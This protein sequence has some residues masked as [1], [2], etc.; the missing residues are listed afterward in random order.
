MFSIR[1]LCTNEGL[2]K[3]G[4]TCAERDYQVTETSAYISAYS[5]TQVYS[6]FF[7][8]WT[9][10]LKR[11]AINEIMLIDKSVYFTVYSYKKNCTVWSQK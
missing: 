6:F 1:H 7:S 9:D 2:L 5:A 8:A 4:S 3:S 11:K 10:Y